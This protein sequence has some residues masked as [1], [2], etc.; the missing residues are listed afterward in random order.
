MFIIYFFVFIFG[1]I[2]GSFLNVCIFRIPL[3]QSIAFPPSHCMNCGKRLKWYDMFPII[4][5]LILKGNCRFCGS[6]ISCRYPLVEVIT[7]I[8]FLAIYLKYGFTFET[9]KFC[10]FASIIIVIGL[11]DMDTMDV[12]TSTIIFGITSAGVFIIIGY[13]LFKMNLDVKISAF[14]YILGGAIGAGF[15]LFI[16]LLARI[17]FKTQGMGNGDTEI[18]FVCGLFLGIENVVFML[19]LSV[20]VGGIS[21]ILLILFGKKKK[22]DCIPFGPFIAISSIISILFGQGII[23]WYLGMI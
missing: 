3:E 14:N 4:S 18:C 1:T 9:I 21:G 17:V 10:V 12:Y 19:L 13:V 6:K 2:I 5:W 15:I 20:I 8:I 16:M 22:T 11:I 7:G 23:N